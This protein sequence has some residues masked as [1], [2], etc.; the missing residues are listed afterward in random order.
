MEDSPT[1]M[2]IHMNIKLYH[3]SKIKN[4][5]DQKKTQV[6]P[7]LEGWGSGKHTCARPAADQVAG[8][9]QVGGELGK[10]EKWDGVWTKAELGTRWW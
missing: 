4:L 2:D 3:K 9:T 8:N 5:K 10:T 1:C 6:L 7:G